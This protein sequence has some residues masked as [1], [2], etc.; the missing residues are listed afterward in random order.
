[1][2]KCGV[3]RC[4]GD[5]LCQG[6]VN[7]GPSKN[8]IPLSLWQ[9][10]TNFKTPTPTREYKN[11][12]LGWFTLLN[13][14]QY[15][16]CGKTNLKSHQFSPW[17]TPWNNRS[18]LFYFFLSFL[19]F[20]YSYVHTLC[21]SFLSSTSALIPHTLPLPS[22]FQTEPVLPFSPILLKR[23]HEHNKEEKAFLLLELTIAIQKDS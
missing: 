2:S 11:K 3:S 1:M 16:V 19:L 6:N 5:I 22:H 9:R 17:N 15:L 14:N 10:E 12:H 18:S 20:I 21:E 7:S 23:I 13:I 8:V 4:L